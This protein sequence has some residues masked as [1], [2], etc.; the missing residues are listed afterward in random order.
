[1]T[2]GKNMRATLCDSLKLPGKLK[3]AFDRR[4]SEVNLHKVTSFPES[5]VPQTWALLSFPESPVPQTWVLL[6]FQCHIKPFLSSVHFCSWIDLFL[7][8][9]KC[10]MKI[11][12]R[13]I[14]IVVTCGSMYLCLFNIDYNVKFV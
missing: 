11:C 3:F 4:E 1:M 14:L 12:Y 9:Y 6:S 13:G 10:V 8:S 5:P 2:H 7:Q